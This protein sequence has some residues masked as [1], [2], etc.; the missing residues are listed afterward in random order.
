MSKTNSWSVL[1]SCVLKALISECTY[2]SIFISVLADCNVPQEYLIHPYIRDKVC[3]NVIV[4]HT[5][6]C[7]TGESL[8]LA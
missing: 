8:L 4:F 3:C 6:L 7:V 2:D 1:I 5:I